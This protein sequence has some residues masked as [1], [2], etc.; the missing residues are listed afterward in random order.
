VHFPHLHDTFILHPFFHVVFS[1]WAVFI[2]VLRHIGC[3]VYRPL[4]APYPVAGDLL[5]PPPPLPP[6]PGEPLAAPPFFPPPEISLV[7][8]CS[9]R[10][11]VF[12]ETASNDAHIR[13]FW[14]YMY[15]FGIFY[16]I[17]YLV[18]LLLLYRE[19][20]IY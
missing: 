12:V 14:H 17:K 9:K 4:G 5:P 18:F 6:P 3:R 16:N 15:I 10:G 11:T 1:S 13:F 8:F 20:N 2:L 7:I 19:L